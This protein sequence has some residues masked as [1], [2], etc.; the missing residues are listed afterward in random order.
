MDKDDSGWVFFIGYSLGTPLIVGVII[1]LVG[2]P[3]GQISIMKDLLV[4]LIGA[5]LAGWFVWNQTSETAKR[6]KDQAERRHGAARAFMPLA[7]SKMTSWSGDVARELERVRNELSDGNLTP[8][9]I[10]PKLDDSIMPLFRDIIE[11]GEKNIA[12]KTTKLISDYQIL[13]S[14]VQELNANIQSI[15]VAVTQHNFFD[16]IVNAT[17]IHARCGAL[18]PYARHET[19][20]APKNYPTVEEV[21]RSL[22]LLDFDNTD[23]DHAEIYKIATVRSER[24]NGQ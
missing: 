6:E 17:T 5:L 22:W 3:P 16:Y 7:L 24:N 4:P 14:R 20:N 21:N 1:G 9:F 19:E 15:N 2:L 13:R 18:F 11:Y 10:P 12:M 8:T 23:I